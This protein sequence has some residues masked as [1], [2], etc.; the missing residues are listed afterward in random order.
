MRD[1]DGR[2]VAVYALNY[3]LCQAENIEFGR[4]SGSRDSRYRQYFAERIFD[5]TP[6]L[7]AY[8]KTNQEIVCDHCAERHESS[9]LSALRMFG[10]LCPAC[11]TGTCQIVNL[12]RKYEPMLRQVDEASLLP[13]VELGI[14]H[15][16]KSSS[17]PPNASDVAAE[18]DCSYQLIGRRAKHLDERGLLDR[19]ED[20]KNRRIYRATELAQ[21]VYFEYSDDDN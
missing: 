17:E 10:M 15:T 7:D 3:G 4:P 8:V 21:S 20:G 18:L 5:F 13:S 12:S 1:R 16:L 6:I 14:L 2:E 9:Q 11:K 19:S